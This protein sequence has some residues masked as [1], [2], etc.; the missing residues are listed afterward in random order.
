MVIYYTRL[1]ENKGGRE[2]QQK[3]QPIKR[4]PKLSPLSS[5]KKWEEMEEK[6]IECMQVAYPTVSF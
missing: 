2:E 3:Q 6:Y 4:T 1:K 5:V